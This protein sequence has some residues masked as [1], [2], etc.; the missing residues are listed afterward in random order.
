MWRTGILRAF[1][2]FEHAESSLHERARRA[3]RHGRLDSTFDDGEPP[4]DAW[5]RQ[6]VARREDPTFSRMA[7]CKRAGGAGLDR[8]DKRFW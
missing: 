7:S 6:I 4:Q 2:L 8:C 1:G 5:E 3:K